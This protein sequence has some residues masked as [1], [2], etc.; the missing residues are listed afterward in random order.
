MTHDSCNMTQ[1]LR[2]ASCVTG[3]ELHCGILV[4]KDLHEIREEV[5]KDN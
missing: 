5:R 1:N 3:H 2:H 4:L